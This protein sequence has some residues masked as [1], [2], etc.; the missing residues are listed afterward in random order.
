M[1]SVKCVKCSRPAVVHL[2]EIGNSNQET[3]AKQ[4]MQIHLCL[5]HAM[6][7]GLLNL[8]AGVELF[9]PDDATTDSASESDLPAV[10][11]TEGQAIVPAGS[12]DTPGVRTCPVCGMTWKM[13]EK[14]GRLN[15]PHD[16]VVFETQLVE[17]SRKVHEGRAQHTGKIPSHSDEQ[18]RLMQAR[19]LVLQQK[20]QQAIKSENYEEAAKLRDELKHL[21]PAAPPGA[22]NG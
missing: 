1:L 18:M 8:S 21:D 5:E 19:R 20:L 2:T 14:R 10:A 4:I 3:G 6:E 12:K 22:V 13:F 17:L 9:K 16:Y 7:A 11:E 15:C